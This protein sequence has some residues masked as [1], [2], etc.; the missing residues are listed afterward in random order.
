M[1]LRLESPFVMRHA[2]CI[3]DPDTFL[4]K[5]FASLKIGFAIEHDVLG[6]RATGKATEEDL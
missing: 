4:E 3:V 2:I 5:L 1:T 6:I